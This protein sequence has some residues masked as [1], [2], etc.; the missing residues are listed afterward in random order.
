MDATKAQKSI[1][2]AMSATVGLA[3]SARL[4]SRP[5]DAL[6]NP[7]NMLRIFVGGVAATLGL[8]FLAY[9]QPDLAKMLAWLVAFGTFMTYGAPIMDQLGKVLTQNWTVTTNTKTPT[10]KTSPGSTTKPGAGTGGGGGGGG[11]W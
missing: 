9:P 8:M 7:G 1:L 4:I 5:G 3:F 11:G 6:R 10:N 2:L